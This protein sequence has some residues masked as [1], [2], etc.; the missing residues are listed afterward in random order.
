VFEK[1]ALEALAT[2]FE[3]GKSEH[4]SLSIE[5]AA[6]GAHVAR[7]VISGGTAAAEIGVLRAGDV[8]LACACARGDERA[9]AIFRER[10]G[11]AAARTVSAAA[12]TMPLTSTSSIASRSLPVMIRETSR[13][14]CT[15]DQPR[16]A[17]SGVLSSCEMVAR[18]RGSDSIPCVISTS[19]RVSNHVGRHDVLQCR[20]IRSIQ[21]IGKIDGTSLQVQDAEGRTLRAFRSMK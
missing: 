16:I 10:Y 18:R 2:L 4:S 15:L 3:A 13:K 19:M 5:P 8:S 17:W 7:H 14:S 1:D 9:V 20:T 11:P 6:F 12:S 21:S